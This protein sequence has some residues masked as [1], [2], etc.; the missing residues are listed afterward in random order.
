[1]P[2]RWR[3]IASALLVSLVVVALAGPAAG[4]SSERTNWRFLTSNDGLVESWTFDATRGPSGRL[5]ISHG[6]VPEIS[7]FDGYRV[8]RL[9]S[10][11]PY[12]T[13][14]EGSDGRR[15]TR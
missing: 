5:F 10:P 13:V 15:S 4:Q 6:E 2:P 8:E 3:R 7:V 11:G 9:P 12:L 1:M 14:R